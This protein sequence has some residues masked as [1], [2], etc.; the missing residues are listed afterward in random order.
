MVKRKFTIS[1]TN[2]QLIA[3]KSRSNAEANAA[4]KAKAAANDKKKR[5][6]PTIFSIDYTKNK[7]K[8]YELTN[9]ETDAVF[10]FITDNKIKRESYF[11]TS[12][13]LYELVKDMNAL[14]I[15]VILYIANKLKYNSNLFTANYDEMS[16]DL[17]VA[18]NTIQKSFI[19]ICSSY[20][21]II[22]KTNV[23][24]TYLINHNVIFKGKLEDFIRDY[25]VMYDGQLALI[26]EKGRVII[27]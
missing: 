13:N 12:I 22:I 16:K 10:K 14:E 4:K 9:D 5:I 23:P 8:E 1:I 2:E 19:S 25:N 26:D 18:A 24:K 17:E 20:N 15:R 7:G 21:N 3:F 11:C 27:K 6:I